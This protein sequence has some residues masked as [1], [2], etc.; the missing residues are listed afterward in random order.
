MDSKG[1][2]KFWVEIIGGVM[3]VVIILTIFVL[4]FSRAA[5]TIE[6]ENARYAFKSFK[7]TI[8]QA[9]TSG[10]GTA[11]P[12]LLKS[13]TDNKAYA[14]TII[15]KDTAKFLSTWEGNQNFH[16][17]E[18]SRRAVKECINDDP[19]DLCYCVVS[20]NYKQ[21]TKGVNKNCGVTPFNLISY[22]Q[23]HFTKSSRDSK[24]HISTIVEEAN[25]WSN[26][27]LMTVVYYMAENFKVLE[28]SSIKHGI[29]SWT[30][31]DGKSWPCLPYHS[32]EEVYIKYYYIGDDF[33]P[34]DFEPDYTGIIVN[35]PIFW[36]SAFDGSPDTLSFSHPRIIDLEL[37]EMDKN[38][39]PEIP[40]GVSTKFT[41]KPL[42]LLD[43]IRPGYDFAYTICSSDMRRPC[44]NCDQCYDDYDYSN[45]N[46][47]VAKICKGD[48]K[49]EFLYHDKNEEAY[50]GKDSPRIF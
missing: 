39:I 1:L 50:C 22:A 11:S 44:A 49:K 28:C 30:D 41:F 10:V 43:E 25:E 33:E 27:Y 15:S 40:W 26:C 35:F 37:L 24:P 32:A 8:T 12:W 45:K 17:S 9:W 47:E 2:A 31:K 42:S 23:D 19:N 14:I 20:I 34:Y 5:A 13:S 29:C 6:D 36:L 48:L 4:V 16:F 46:S 38:K 21:S 3:V 18:E 7:S